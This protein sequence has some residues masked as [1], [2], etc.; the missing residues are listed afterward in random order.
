MVA[1]RK[2]TSWACASMMMLRVPTVSGAMSMVGSR[3]R[4]DSTVSLM[5]PKAPLASCATK[6]GHIQDVLQNN[7]PEGFHFISV[8]QQKMLLDKLPPN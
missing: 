3:L 8:C 1:L 4:A 7:I 2:K 5:W 6:H